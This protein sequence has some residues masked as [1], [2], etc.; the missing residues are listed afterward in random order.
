M[1]LNSSLIYL[2]LLR[3]RKKV[4]NNHSSDNCSNNGF[5][6]TKIQMFRYSQKW[7]Q[8]SSLV[9]ILFSAP[10]AVARERWAAG[11]GKEVAIRR[12]QTWRPPTSGPRV[13][14]ALTYCSV[15][16]GYMLNGKTSK[17]INE[18]Q[19]PCVPVSFHPPCRMRDCATR[20]HEY[21]SNFILNGFENIISC[22]WEL[23]W[24]L[25][26]H[27]TLRQ[28]TVFQSFNSNLH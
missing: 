13:C 8:F 23:D 2:S 16:L 19:T 22:T 10:R 5:F 18:S 25:K 3:I 7:P 12:R 28:Q 4:S 24:I 21:P 17:S 6:R 27:K 15:V 11:W 20:S 26:E 1:A 9:L 14:S